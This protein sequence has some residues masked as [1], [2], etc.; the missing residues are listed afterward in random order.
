MCPA[1]ESIQDHKIVTQGFSGWGVRRV[2]EFRI[3]NATKRNPPMKNLILNRKSRWFVSITTITLITIAGFFL[4]N[5]LGPQTRLDAA[6]GI[7]ERSAIYAP[8]AAG[9]LA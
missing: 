1:G 9:S 4:S 8:A 5:A 7:A 3:Q 2:S 6:S